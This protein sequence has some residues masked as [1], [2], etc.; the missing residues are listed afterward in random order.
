M[1]SHDEAASGTDHSSDLTDIKYFLDDPAVSNFMQRHEKETDSNKSLLDTINAFIAVGALIAGVQAQLVAVT[2]NIPSTRF[3]RATNWFGFVGLILDL[4]GVSAGVIC[5]V[6]LQRAI[7]RT[8]RIAVRLT[9]E[10]DRAR[11]DVDRLRDKDLPV[12]DPS[13]FKSLTD[14]ISV[15]SS[16]TTL[17]SEVNSFLAAGF[18]AVLAAPAQERLDRLK[19]LEL[20]G[21]GGVPDLPLGVQSVGGSVVSLA[22]GTLCLLASVIL[23]ARSSQPH[24]VWVSC[25][26]IAT[27][28]IVY[29]IFPGIQAYLIKRTLYGRIEKMLPVCPPIEP[30]ACSTSKGEA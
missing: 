17:H 20:Q 7:R 10:I 9:D 21:L 3:S 2:Y 18:S 22:G 1:S 4:A 26:A 8:D 15:I 13:V 5:A 27:I 6:L 16:V 19:Q 30:P 28:I 23:F 29:S 25:T 11:R 12:A 24:G 14:R